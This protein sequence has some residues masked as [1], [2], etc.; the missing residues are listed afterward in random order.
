[1]SLSD[2]YRRQFGWR[3]WATIFDALPTLGGQTVLDLGC[4]VGD[5][6]AA[7]VARGARVIG[8][9]TND[10]LLDEARSKALARA[11][12]RKADLRSLEYAGPPADG[13]WCSFTAAYFPDLTHTLE[14]WSRFLRPGGW[15]VLTEIDDLFGHAPLGV[16]AASLLEDYARDALRAGRYDFPHGAKAGKPRRG[17]GPHSDQGVHNRRP[18]VRV[19][20]PG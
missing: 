8:L 10:A 5:L 3:S 11:E 14:S 12:F 20:R 9:D 2:E 17:R 16:R 4:G 6:A 7:L 13:L 18:R 15:V 19:R 1:M